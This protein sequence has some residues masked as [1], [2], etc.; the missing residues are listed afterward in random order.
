MKNLILLNTHS[1]V[2]LI[3]NSSTEMFVSGDKQTV[4]MIRNQILPDIVSGYNIAFNAN[5]T[6]NIFG[7]IFVFRL[8]AYRK[9]IKSI[10]YNKKYEVFCGYFCDIEDN[11]QIVDLRREIIEHG[12]NIDG[13][14]SSMEHI[15]RD[16]INKTRIKTVDYKTNEVNVNKEITLI[17]N[18]LEKNRPLWWDRPWR[19]TS[20]RE[21]NS[22]EGK[23]VIVGS[24]DNTIPYGMFEMINIRLNSHNFHLG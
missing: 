6:M 1:C 19:Y 23:V 22:L 12:P 3:T 4:K 8:D 15:Y 9:F 18:E 11:K 10:K 7:D 2:D 14:W 16:R 17:Y 13:C 21:I 5:I 24:G 20:T